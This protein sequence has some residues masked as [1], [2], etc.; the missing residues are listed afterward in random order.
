MTHQPASIIRIPTAAYYVAPLL[1]GGALGLQILF[2]ILGDR[3]LLRTLLLVLPCVLVLTLGVLGVRLL[4]APPRTWGLI[5]S[6]FFNLAASA[7]AFW[8]TYLAM[9]FP[10]PD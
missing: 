4:A 10:S 8:M 7:L 6:L 2:P 3:Y 5:F 1:Y 9:T